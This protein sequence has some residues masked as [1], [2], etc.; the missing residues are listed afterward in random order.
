MAGPLKTLYRR[1]LLRDPSLHK[2]NV[3]DR[4]REDL[5]HGS[6]S[7]M[8]TVRGS[9][10]T[11]N[12]TADEP[13]APIETSSGASNAGLSRLLPVSSTSP[14]LKTMPRF[15]CFLIDDDNT[16]RSFETLE[17]ANEEE[18]THRAEEMLRSSSRAA[19]IEIWESGRFVTRIPRGKGSH[20]SS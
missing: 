2:A 20:L 1:F 9:V 8:V 6:G 7:H 10:P 12:R 19:S 17:L 3:F 11:S 18:A 4:G 13:C 14:G 16:V 15:R 5:L